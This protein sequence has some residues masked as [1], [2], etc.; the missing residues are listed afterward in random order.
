[1][2]KGV[3]FDLEGTVVDVERAH[4]LGHF[5]AAKEVG[6]VLDLDSAL[7]K[8]PHFIGGPD[9]KIAEEILALSP[10]KEQSTSAQILARDKYWCILMDKANFWFAN[11][12]YKNINIFI[13]SGVQYP[14]SCA[15]VKRGHIGAAA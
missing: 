3:A 1:M 7:E 2:I 12:S 14:S 15:S 9:D 10:Q 11:F 5:A 6:V 13:D 4:H 8:L